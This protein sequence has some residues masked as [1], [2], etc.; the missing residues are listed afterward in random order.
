MQ[1]I[2]THCHIHDSEFQ[3]KYDQPVDQ[4]LEE[5]KSSGVTKLICVGTDL[6]SSLEAVEFANS[7]EGCFASLAIHPHEAKS[8]SDEDLNTAFDEFDKLCANERVVAIG[9]CGLDYYYHD[10]R[11]VRQKQRTM[12]I[13]HLQLAEKYNLPIIFHVRDQ[14]QA[15]KGEKTAFD[16]LFELL[17]QHENV[18]GVIHSFSTN[19]KV[20]ERV[21]SYGLYVGLNGIMTFSKNEEQLK[22]ARLVPRERL[23]LE[24]DAPFLTPTPFRG[25]MCKP[26]HIKLT[27]SF[28]AKLRGES[29]EEVAGYTTANAEK[30]FE[31]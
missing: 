7:H 15:V 1:L 19:S 30:L 12:L 20:L 11:D 13:K 9:E 25:K 17:D 6:K 28:L 10:D 26:E 5:A 31:I 2:D 16:E 21:I 27:A 14:K 3:G 24:T 22:A 29:L 4:I 23:L 8:A 18:R